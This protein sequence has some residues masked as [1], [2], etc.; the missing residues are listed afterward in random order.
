MNCK[1]SVFLKCTCILLELVN[2]FDVKFNLYNEEEPSLIDH[3]LS[4]TYYVLKVINLN[5]ELW[6]PKRVRYIYGIDKGCGNDY[7]FVF[8]SS[9]VH[10]YVSLV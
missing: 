9:R 5:V 10:E 3:S 1:M 7:T 6:R 2:E 8:D 4:R